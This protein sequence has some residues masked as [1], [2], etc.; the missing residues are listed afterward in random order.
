MKR[1]AA[2][3]SSW[4][5][6]LR[7][8]D[9]VVTYAVYALL[10]LVVAV[11]TYLHHFRPNVFVVPD[12][13]AVTAWQRPA[14][15]ETTIHARMTAAERQ[16]V[17]KEGVAM[18][19]STPDLISNDLLMMLIACLCYCH[20]RKHYGSWMASCFFIG[21]FAFT[22]LVETFWILGGRAL[23]G[24]FR[25][26]PGGTLYGTYWFT[27]GLFWFVETPIV[28]CLGWFAFAYSCVWV[29]SLLFPAVSLAVRA[30]TGGSS[31][32]VLT[33]GRTPCRPRPS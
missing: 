5:P 17:E 20:A 4:A 8:A 28:A 1:P 21:S 25:L 30:A 9:P 19:K 6:A 12:N 22:G 2:A 23:G 24:V 10:V 3:T 33:Y 13:L 16:R 29:A 32:W 31:P 15:P 7:D 11:S 18:A 27:K 14:F 26:A